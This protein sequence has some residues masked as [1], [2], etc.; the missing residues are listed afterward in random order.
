MMWI[1]PLQLLEVSNVRGK[2]T[3]LFH[4]A[5]FT[6]KCLSAVKG[7]FLQLDGIG[8]SEILEKV[9]LSMFSVLCE[10]WFKIKGMTRLYLDTIYLEL[11]PLPKKKEN[12]D[13]R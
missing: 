5:C 10:L 11:H 9:M 2:V 13:S 1:F 3:C 6:P 4:V 12:G 7:P 8:N